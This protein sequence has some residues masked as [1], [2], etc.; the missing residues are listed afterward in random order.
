M[1]L[2]KT[3]RRRQLNL[4][5]AFA[6]SPSTPP[7]ASVGDDDG[8]LEEIPEDELLLPEEDWTVREN[9]V[10]LFSFFNA[11]AAAVVFIQNSLELQRRLFLPL[12]PPCL[13]RPSPSG[14][15]HLAH[16]PSISQIESTKPRSPEAPTTP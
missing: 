11:A 5:A 7:A 3:L 14:K 4:V 15:T 6:S 13:A 2:P 10:F 16:L 1:T 8:E 9:V 12:P